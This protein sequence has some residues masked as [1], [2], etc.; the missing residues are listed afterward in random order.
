M[1]THRTNVIQRRNNRS[2]RLARPSSPLQMANREQTYQPSRL[3]SGHDPSNSSPMVVASNS[4]PCNDGHG[5]FPLL[6]SPA[7]LL[8]PSM[9]YFREISFERRL[10]RACL[11]NGYDLLVDPTTDPDNV[12]VFRL[13]LIFSDRDSIVQWVQGLLEA[14]L[15]EAQRCGTC[16][17][18]C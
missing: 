10:H 1:E 3:S 15:E 17:S 4:M 18:S 7:Y 12:R 5:T 16:P 8:S 13:P 6:V 2:R 9:A 11:K 14:G